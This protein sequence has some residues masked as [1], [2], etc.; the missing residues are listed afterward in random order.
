[1]ANDYIPG[2]NGG[3]H[4]WQNNFVTTSTPTRKARPTGMMG[5]N[6][7]RVAWASR[8]RIFAADSPPSGPGELTFP[9]VDTRMP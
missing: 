8:L 1:M 7:T 9:A 6:H 5:V 4:A 3:F 2:P